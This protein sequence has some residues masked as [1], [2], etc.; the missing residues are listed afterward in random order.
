V[1]ERDPL[2]GAG[3]AYEQ[4]TLRIEIKNGR[5]AIYKPISTYP[6][7]KEN[8]MKHLKSIIIV[9]LLALAFAFTAS[10][11]ETYH[12]SNNGNHKGTTP[13]ITHSVTHKGNHHTDTHHNNTSNKIQ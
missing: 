6:T 11:T 10:A 1:S 8:K 13:S 4:G 12:G 7:I 5:W 3:S 2:I 9:L